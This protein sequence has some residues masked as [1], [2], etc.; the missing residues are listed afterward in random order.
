VSYLSVHT[1]LA[2]EQ[3][4]N[5]DAEITLRQHALLALVRIA[6]E[7]D[8]EA[9]VE[10]DTLA[11]IPALLDSSDADMQ[12]QACLL[13]TLLAKNESTWIAILSINP[14]ERLVELARYVLTFVP[15]L[16]RKCA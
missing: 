5:R 16:A 15:L 2:D 9:L 11:Y 4:H 3:A 13:L 12:Q 8:G 6:M 7:T 1:L 10:A 14:C